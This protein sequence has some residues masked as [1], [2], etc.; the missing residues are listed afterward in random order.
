MRWSEILPSVDV[1]HF[2]RGADPE[3]TGV[4]YDSRRMRAGSLFVAMRG[5]SADGSRYVDAALSSGAAAVITDSAEAYEALHIRGVA[6]ALA[7]HGRHALAEAATAFYDAPQQKL[8]VTAITG[9]NGK[10]TTAFLL[11][12]LLVSAG[13]KVLLIGTVE[14]RIAGER[15]ESTHTTPEASDLIALLAEAVHAGCTEVVMEASSHALEQGRM[16]SVPVDVA[17]L[18]NLTQDHL[19]YHGSME[20]Y[21]RAK[22]RLFSAQGTGSPPRV[23]VINEQAAQAGSFIDAY[24]GEEFVVRYDSQATQGANH[25]AEHVVSHAMGTQF[26]FVTPTDR[27]AIDS[28]LIGGINVENLLAAMCAALARGLTLQSIAAAVPQL[29][30]APG[31]F[32]V[33]SGSR[34]AGFSVVVDY[35]HTPDALENLCAIARE[36]VHA[37]NGRVLTMF[38]CGGDRDRSKRPRMGLA[39]AAGSDF[40]VVTSDNPRSEDPQAI[41]DEIVAG[42]MSSGKPFVIELDRRRAIGLAIRD[43]APGDIVLLAGKGHEKT[44]TF[45]DRSVHFDD[46]EEAEHVLRDLLRSGVRA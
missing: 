25:C 30:A 36:Q 46:V 8:R 3:I 42:M 4:E 12:Q 20:A 39:A 1:E 10:T 18:T 19:D 34:E 32:E 44:Q 29:K 37:T 23:A 9:T 15:R 7:Q 16:W 11:E 5:G 6:S 45:A 31:R 40:V 33:V 27:A 2:T 35:A 43:A 13:R 21:A 38:G 26:E 28:P 41:A 17:V 14:T 22:R 24:D